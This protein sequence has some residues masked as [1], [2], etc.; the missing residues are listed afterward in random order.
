MKFQAYKVLY[1][2]RNKQILV[3]LMIDSYNWPE[4]DEL[5]ALCDS[6]VKLRVERRGLQG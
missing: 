3:F 6:Q 4:S 5:L 1:V 2:D